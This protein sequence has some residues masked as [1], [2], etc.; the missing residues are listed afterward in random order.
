MNVVGF[1]FAHVIL[2]AGIHQ[3]GEVFVDG[4]EE[5]HAEREVGSP[6]ERMPFFAARPFHVGTVLLEPSRTAAHHL[7]PL[8]PGFQ[9]VAVSSGGVGKFD[10]SV[11]TAERIGVEILRIIH[12]DNRHYLVA[13]LQGDF[14]NHVP[15]LAVAYQSK[16][17][18]N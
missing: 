1:H 5:G 4:R 13:T 17:H 3:P 2:R 12:I 15:H 11:G 6:K 8:F 18:G 7:H 10:G 14:L 16:F 9:V